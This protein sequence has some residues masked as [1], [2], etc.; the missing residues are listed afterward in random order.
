MFNTPLL[1]VLD[2]LIGNPETELSDSE[3]VSSVE[4]VARSAVHQSLVRLARLGVV[5]RTNRGR[6]CYNI[7]DGGHA[8]I[9]PL[10]V[11]VNLMDLAPL[12]ETM[13]PH[14]AK[15]VLFGSRAD[16]TDRSASDYDLLVVSNEPDAVRRI[17]VKGDLDGRLQLIVKT[18]SEMLDF[19]SREPVFAET[20]RKGVVLWE[21]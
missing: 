4:S 3:I 20:L 9:R 17:V 15:I 1:R 10:K 7:L 14:S 16:G 6:R 5:R 13:R 2:V 11:A 12:V 8:W 18:P 21:R 19:A